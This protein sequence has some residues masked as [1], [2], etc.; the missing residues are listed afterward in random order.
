[1]CFNFNRIYNK[2]L[3]YGSPRAYLIHNW[4]AIT[5]VS[6]CPLQKPRED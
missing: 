2:M 3:D 1:M 5:W 6:N 4:N